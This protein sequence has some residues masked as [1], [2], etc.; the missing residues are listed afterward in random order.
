MC[1]SAPKLLNFDA[2]RVSRQ[3]CLAW[4]LYVVLDIYANY[5]RCVMLAD[6]VDLR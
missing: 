4:T 3:S 2:N 5:L 1:S 6:T